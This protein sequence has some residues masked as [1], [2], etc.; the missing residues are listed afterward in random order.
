MA[1]YDLLH[2]KKRANF[3][4]KSIFATWKHREDES[5]VWYV[6]KRRNSV[7]TFVPLQKLA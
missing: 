6:S 2:W 5:R 3:S 1:I 4:E 7:K